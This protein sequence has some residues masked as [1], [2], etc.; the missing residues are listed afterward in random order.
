V[1]SIGL[2]IDP[3]TGNAVGS[4]RVDH[5]SD[6]G[7]SA[8]VGNVSAFAVGADGEMYI[9]NHTGGTVVKVVSMPV[10]PAAPTNLRIIR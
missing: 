9:V 3:G 1:W 4:A 5:T 10:A 2:T 8:V 6:L 7:G